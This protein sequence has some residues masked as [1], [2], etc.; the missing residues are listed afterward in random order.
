MSFAFPSAEALGVGFR[1]ATDAD[2][3]FLSRLYASTRWEELAQTG[4]PD[5]AK[6]RFL[7]D[8]FELQRVHYARHRPNAERMVIERAGAPAGRLYIDETAERLH[9]VDIALLPDSCG[10]G[11]GSAILGDL[12]RLAE[13]SGR[14][15][16]I[17]VE[18]YNPALSL[19]RRLGFVPVREEGA[20][21]FMEC[22]PGT[23]FDRD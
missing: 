1:P 14:I 19:Y 23:S 9:I 2:L 15:V 8:Q 16:S 11:I 17:F 3:P 22:G 13:A 18:K 10:A 5:E 7:L 21:D 6:A 12:L 4:W 20:Y